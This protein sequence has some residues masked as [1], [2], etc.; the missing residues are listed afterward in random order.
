MRHVEKLRLR[1]GIGSQGIKQ[2]CDAL[3]E[4]WRSAPYMH[5]GRSATVRDV[6]E[7]E[8]HGNVSALSPLQIDELVAYLETL[9]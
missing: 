2:L 5:D 1:V 3:L 9:E 4:L 8:H 7:T 6:I